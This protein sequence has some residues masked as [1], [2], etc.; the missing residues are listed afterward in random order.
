MSLRKIS[1][2]EVNLLA[3]IAGSIESDYS[4]SMDIWN[5]SPFRW[6]KA[7]PS[8]RSKGAIGESLVAGWCAAKGLNVLR[9]PDSQAD[10]IIQ[11]RRIE[12]KFSTLWE[13]GVYKFQQIRDQ[14]YDF[15]FCLGI[16][17]FDAHAWLIPKA[18]LLEHVIGHMGQHTGAT[19]TDTAW[20]SVEPE[21]PYAWMEA[22]GGRLK[23]TF[24]LIKEI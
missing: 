23:D 7:H 4:D 6:I 19:G 12:I 16:A 10:R 21:R 3:S 2:P 13:T 1:D 5:G 15:V 9:S 17:P 8:A 14:N 24:R 11:G 22:C 20:I 18:V